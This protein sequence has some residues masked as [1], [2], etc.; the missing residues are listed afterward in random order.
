MSNNV[1]I[2]DNKSKASEEEEN[3]ADSNTDIQSLPERE[4]QNAIIYLEHY[5]KS[6]EYLRYLWERDYS[7]I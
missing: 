4:A 6:S 5:R 1:S 2:T 7:K 3:D